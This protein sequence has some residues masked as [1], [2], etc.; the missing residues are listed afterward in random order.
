MRPKKK[1]MRKKGRGKREE[2]G[3]KIRRRLE[4]KWRGGE[5]F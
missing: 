1:G 2:E 4:G 5:G 3:E